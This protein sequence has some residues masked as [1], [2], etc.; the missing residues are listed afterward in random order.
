MD[1]TQRQ[2]L[3]EQVAGAIDEHAP[4]IIDLADQIHKR[5]EINFQERFASQLLADR[6]RAEGFER[7]VSRSRNRSAG[8]KRP[9]GRRS[10]GAATARRSRCWPSTTPSRRSGMAAATT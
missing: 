1:D 7:R 2:G 9:F 3:R 5:P 6:L 8:L 10:A 4:G